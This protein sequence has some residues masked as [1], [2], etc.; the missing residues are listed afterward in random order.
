MCCQNCKGTGC[1]YCKG[2]GCKYCNYTGICLDTATIK[3]VNNQRI[4]FTTTGS[5]WALSGAGPCAGA[6]FQD[7]KLLSMAFDLKSIQENRSF[8]QINE[9]DTERYGL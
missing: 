8:S 3:A 4:S 6:Y 1:K 2:A 7:T 9:S 5:Q